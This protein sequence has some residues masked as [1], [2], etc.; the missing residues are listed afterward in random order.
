MNCRR[1]GKK[2]TIALWM[3]V[4][5]ADVAILVA[6][7]GVVTMLLILAGL[8]VLGGGVVAARMLMNSQRTPVPVRQRSAEAAVVRR[9]A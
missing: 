9:R 5:I 3:L 1:H 8:L 4:A 2:P 7:A 6:A